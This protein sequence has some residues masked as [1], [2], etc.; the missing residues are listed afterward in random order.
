MEFSLDKLVAVL[1]SAPL[2]A[3]LMVGVFT[4]AALVYNATESRN[5]EQE[6]E[7]NFVLSILSGMLILALMIVSTQV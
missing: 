5:L 2:I 1:Q 7:F 3:I 6:K 4:I